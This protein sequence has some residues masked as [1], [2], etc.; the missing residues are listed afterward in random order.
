MS[1]S[2]QWIFEASRCLNCPTQPCVAACPAHNPI[3]EFMSKIK[4]SDFWGAWRLW[5]Q[6]S[7]LPE[8][9]GLLCPQEILCE[10]QCTLNKAKR[11]V[12]IGRL[13]HAIGTMFLMD[14]TRPRPI[15][16]QR[17]LVIGL[18]PAGIANALKMAEFGYQVHAIEADRR[19]GGAIYHYVPDFRFSEAELDIYDARLRAL[20]VQITYDTVVGQDVMLDSLLHMYDSVFIANGLDQP[21]IVPFNQDGLKV[22]YAI[23]LLHKQ[24]VSRDTL[25][26]SLGER[27]GIIGLGFV[28]IDMAR[29]LVRLDKR[30][31]IIYRRNLNEAPASEKEITAAQ[32]EGVI[33][34]ELL[35]PVAFCRGHGSNQLECV[36][37]RLVQDGPDARSRIETIPGATVTFELDDLI[38][39]TGQMSEDLCLHQT[40]IKIPTTPDHTQTNHE[41]VFVGGDRIITHKRIV[42]AMVSGIE[43]AE[44]I[45]E[46][47]QKKH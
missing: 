18:G 4:Q 25:R 47:L 15:L 16:S 17:H 22:H 33:I 6:T 38:F 1:D 29:T 7:N 5:Q 14:E 36:R 30:V 9:C 3:P 40:S 45:H 31:E 12:Q 28:A 34:H 20:G 35:G 43:T 13:E 42:D 19:L 10:G 26:H 32:E 37:T 23:D 39:A 21:I 2:Q 46:W 41:K 8:L 24:R 11:P 27:I 44:R